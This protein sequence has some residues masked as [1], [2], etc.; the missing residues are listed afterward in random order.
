MNIKVTTTCWQEKKNKYGKNE[1]AIQTKHRYNE[2]LSCKK[3]STIFIKKH[4]E[5][6]NVFRKARNKMH[7][8]QE[9]T[10]SQAQSS[11]IETSSPFNPLVLVNLQLKTAGL[12]K[13]M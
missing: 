3:R 4:S 9:I 10:N 11:T 7:Q 1:W 8:P 12:L 13:F 5:N 2:A 6:Q